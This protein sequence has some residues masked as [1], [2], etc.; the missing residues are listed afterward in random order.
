MRGPRRRACRELPGS[1]RAPLGLPRPLSPESGV[2]RHLDVSQDGALAGQSQA[3]VRVVGRQAQTT[4]LL[5]RGSR[6]RTFHLDG[7]R[8]T[9]TAAPAVD[10][11]GDARVQ[12][13]ACA[14]Q[15]HAEIGAFRAGNGATCE[16]DCG[17]AWTRLCSLRL[18]AA[19]RNPH[20]L[21]R[22]RALRT[23]TSR[24]VCRLSA[25]SQLPQWIHFAE[26]AYAPPLGILPGR[27]ERT[28]DDLPSDPIALLTYEL[29]P[30]RRSRLLRRSIGSCARR[31][32]RDSAPPA[33]A[34]LPSP[35]RPGASGAHPG[36]TRP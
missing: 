13:E 6:H 22:P 28:M 4:D 27:G 26:T 5:R 31:C 17:Q 15:H 3:G 12:G 1:S 20:S 35:A 30:G 23:R 34:T 11:L 18:D 24:S 8:P 33:A 9:Q 16:T 2:L 29:S 10:R 32:P 25:A 7:T 19:G 21:T 36:A 14:K